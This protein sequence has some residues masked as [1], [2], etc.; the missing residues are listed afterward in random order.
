MGWGIDGFK[1][2]A[3]FAVPNADDRRFFYGANFEFSINAKRWDEHRYTSEVRPIIGWHL[4]NGRHHRQSDSRHGLRRPEEPRL[5]P[6]DARRLQGRAEPRSWRSRSTPTTGRCTSS[7]GA[8]EQVHQ[9]YGVVD[10]TMCSIDLEAG[11]R[12]RPDQC[13]RQ[14]HVQADPVAR[15]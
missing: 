2:R 14:G 3:L 6:G 15:L 12:L 1:L 11:R 4:G 10:H 7:L 5:R 9:I 13:L 8:S